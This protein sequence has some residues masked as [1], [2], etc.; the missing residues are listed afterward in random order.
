MKKIITILAVLMFMLLCAQSVAAQDAL[1][2]VTAAVLP[3]E[4]NAK[5]THISED[6]TQEFEQRYDAHSVRDVLM[7]EAIIV[8]V[9]LITVVAFT[10]VYIDISM[11]R[12]RREMEIAN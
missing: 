5:V 6:K 3:T 10:M 9:E 7:S 1:S 2:T 12:K 11:K 4:A 8:G